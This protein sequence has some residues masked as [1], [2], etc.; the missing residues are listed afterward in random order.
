MKLNK[1][2]ALICFVASDKNISRFVNILS[3]VICESIY[4]LYGILIEGADI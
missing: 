4:I 2:V 1:N 3:Y